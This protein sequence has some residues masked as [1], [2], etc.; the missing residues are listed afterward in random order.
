MEQNTSLTDVTR[1][2]IRLL[3]QEIESIES[4]DSSIQL[5][6]CK[7]FE[8]GETPALLPTHAD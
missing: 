7:L 6:I 4:S 8:G 1:C 5:E 3:T 2:T